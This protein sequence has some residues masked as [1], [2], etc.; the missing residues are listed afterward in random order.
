MIVECFSILNELDLLEIHLNHMALYVDRFVIC[1][2]PVSYSGKSKPMFYAENKDRFACFNIDY[3]VY[4][5]HFDPD[6]PIGNTDAWKRERT[7]RAF[8]IK[9]ALKN[10]AD[11]DYLIASDV[12]EM[13]DMEHWNHKEGVFAMRVFNY[14]LNVQTGRQYQHCSVIAKKK[15][16]DDPLFHVNRRNTEETVGAG[17]HFTSLG[18][19]EDLV[20]KL[21]MGCHLF[22]DV[23]TVKDQIIK[24]H[25]DLV[26]PYNRVWNGR[27]RERKFR[28]KMPSGPKWLLEN[29]EKY[30]HHLYGN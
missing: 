24:N 21:E 26:D 4:D 14:Y 2:S 22:E 13:P 10:M 15:N 11:D 6:C 30:R 20:Y 5:G 3:V 28:V 29:I 8:L 17:W 23:D 1:E 16:I 9:Y 7:Q 27:I 19:P 25:K 18:D 12:D